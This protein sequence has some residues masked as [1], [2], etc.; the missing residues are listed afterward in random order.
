M[1]DK[2]FIAG[3]WSAGI[4]SAVSCKM[5]LE[6]YDNVQ[7]Y[8]IGINTAHPD[9]LR[10]KRDCEKWYG[11]EIHT[12]KSKEFNNQFEV[13]EKVRAVNTP[14]GAPCTQ[15]LKKDVRFDFETLNEL[16]L[17]NNAVILN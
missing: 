6:L 7:L 2:P 13:I 4:T 16:S 14:Y 5:A 1:N 12:L 11:K 17:F 15:R 10:F 9:N 8:Y 3:W